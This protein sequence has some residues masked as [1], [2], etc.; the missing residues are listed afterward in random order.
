[1]SS[2]CTIFK[3]RYFVKNFKIK[4]C[5][6]FHPS[7]YNAPNGEKYKILRSLDFNALYGMVRK[8]CFTF[9]YEISRTLI[10]LLA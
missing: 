7:V 8:L 5:G 6:D 2:T 1:M 9:L 4:N 10:K 3:Y